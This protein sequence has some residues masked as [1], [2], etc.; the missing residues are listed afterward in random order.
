MHITVGIAS[1]THIIEPG[2]KMA[3][4][5]LIS[6]AKQINDHFTPLDVEHKG[7]Y[8][9]IVLCGK[10]KKLEDN[11]WGLYIVAG[12]F[13]SVAEKSKYVF[14][15]PNTEYQKYIYLIK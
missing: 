3:K 10:V 7:H 9:G 5:A 13:E 15:E 2:I 11:E 4:S 8:I 6:M 1:T 14:G 12:I